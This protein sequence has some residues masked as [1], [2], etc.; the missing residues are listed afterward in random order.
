[1]VWMSEKEGDR[2]GV[3]Q[4]GKGA[5]EQHMGRSPRKH[6]KGEGKTKG[7]QTNLQ[8]AK[9]S[10]AEHWDRKVRHS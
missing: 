1:M 7:G 10:V 2:G 5:V 8:N 4:K 6:S 9:R 3:S